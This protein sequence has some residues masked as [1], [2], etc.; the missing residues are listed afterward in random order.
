[1][2]SITMALVFCLV[3]SLALAGEELAE[4][5]FV[6]TV[7]SDGIE[8]VSMTGGSYFFDPNVIVVKVNVPVE[9]TVVKEP[10]A[11]PHNLTLKA[12]EAGIDI[13][14]DLSTTP[15][16]IK[17]TPTKTGTYPFEC[18]ERFLFFK[19]HKDRGMHGVLEVVE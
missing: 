4:K 10:G 7:G 9:L 15:K 17:F 1:M 3:A 11:T 16:I 12:P 13:S 18:T 8:H 6:A 5:R 14:E 19:S 2:R